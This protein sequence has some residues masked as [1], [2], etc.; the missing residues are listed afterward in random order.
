MRH[1]KGCREHRLCK[2]NVLQHFLDELHIGPEQVLAVGD[3]ENDICLLRNSGISVAFQP[4][5]P[6]VL[7]AAKNILEEDLRGVLRLIGQP[8]SA[9]SEIRTIASVEREAQ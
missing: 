5:R 3:S 7:Q 8:V 4:K 2:L 1:P 9:Q 6:A